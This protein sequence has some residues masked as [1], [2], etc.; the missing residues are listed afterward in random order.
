MSKK[1]VTPH[2]EGWGSPKIIWDHPLTRRG[3]TEGSHSQAGSS[4][5]GGTPHEE[6]WHVPKI[7][8]TTPLEEGWC[9]L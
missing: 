8:N 2:E 3:A 6:G 9:R 7:K 4:I 5:K 1:K